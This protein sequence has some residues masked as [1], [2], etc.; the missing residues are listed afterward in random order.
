MF[1]PDRPLH[2]SLDTIASSGLV[3]QYHQHSQE[4]HIGKHY[5]FPRFWKLFRNKKHHSHISTSV[6]NQ[7][8]RLRHSIMA[9]NHH[10]GLFPLRGHVLRERDSSEHRNRSIHH[11]M[12]LFDRS[13]LVLGELLGKGAFCLVHELQDVRLND[14]MVRPYFSRSW[15]DN[16][17]HQADR[18]REYVRRTCNSK[19][20]DDCCCDD[21]SKDGSGEDSEITQ[22]TRYVVKH[23]RPNL[24]TERSYKVFVHAAA[25]LRMEYEILARLSHPNIV[26]LRGGAVLEM[27]SSSW[28]PRSMDNEDYFLLLERLDE[29]LTQRIHCWKKLEST[30][31]KSHGVDGSTSIP[32]FFLEKLRFARDVASA[33]A[34]IHEQRFVFRDLKPD[35][36]GI[37][38]DGNVK[39]F[40]FGLC[41]E[42]PKL[43]KAHAFNGKEPLFRMSGVGTRRYMA[44]E[45]IM[46]R[47]YNQKIDCYSWAMVFYEMIS[48]QKPYD[49]YNRD[50]HKVLVCENEDRPRPSLDVPLSARKLLQRAWAQKPCDRPPMTEIHHELEMMIDSTERQAL[51]VHERSLKVIME[52]AE[53][54]SGDDSNYPC[55][56]KDDSLISRK[57]IA[58]LTV[59]TSTSASSEM[60]LLSSATSL[61]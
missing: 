47:G 51:T 24:A 40:D 38:H 54:F 2:T 50:M 29:T 4:T 52:M 8:S 15:W 43:S 21:P 46:G 26:Q 58:E 16:K 35:N 41:R 23:L 6:Q 42:L 7:D 61:R 34:Y 19:T 57:S 22:H 36:V 12:A 59:S 49:S 3:Q 37:A 14:G 27:S 20:A 13:E 28:I 1:S 60:S 33:L 17:L 18:T 44:P 53:L 30:Q 10:K 9:Q 56:K 31:R 48:L 5:L 25:D 55:S 39:L 32:P 11:N 45:M